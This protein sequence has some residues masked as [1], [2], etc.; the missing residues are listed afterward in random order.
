[1][2]MHVCACA[3]QAVTVRQ[4]TEDGYMQIKGVLSGPLDE[5]YEWEVLSPSSEK[6]FTSEVVEEVLIERSKEGEDITIFIR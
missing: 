5:D 6:S 2:K 1:M 4:L 3:G